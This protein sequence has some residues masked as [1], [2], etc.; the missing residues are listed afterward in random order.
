MSR[1]IHSRGRSAN[2]P[3]DAMAKPGQIIHSPA[4]TTARNKDVLTTF[5][6]EPFKSTSTYDR[7]LYLERN[8]K[9]PNEA[10]PFLKFMQSQG[11][12]FDN[13]E[14][15]RVRTIDINENESKAITR[16]KIHN[17]VQSSVSR[18]NKYNCRCRGIQVL[19]MPQVLHHP[20]FKRNFHN[21][22]S[23]ILKPF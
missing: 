10:H 1:R 8:C 17:V 19:E 9:N 13:T 3:S 18:L 4:T 20:S 2:I 12:G 7:L 14:D 5:F 11:F 16:R 21:K 15:H 6:Q 23:Y 22:T